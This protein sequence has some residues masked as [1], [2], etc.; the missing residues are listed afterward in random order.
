M[1]KTGKYDAFISYRH[2]EPDNEIASK[3]QKKL[4]SF[5]FHKD[6]AAKEGRTKARC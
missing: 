6:I 4:E 5:R 1:A 2:C 3:I